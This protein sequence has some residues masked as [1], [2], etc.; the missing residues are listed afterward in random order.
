M[1]RRDK[2]EAL[3]AVLGHP[4]PLSGVEIP[5]NA[6][7][8]L[9]GK[10]HQSEVAIKSGLSQQMISEIERGTRHLTPE[11]A[12]KLAPALGVDSQQ[13]LLAH[14][15]GVL[16]KAAL[17]GAV[18]PNRLVEAVMALA[19][20][21]PDDDI[22]DQLVDALVEVLRKAVEN[23]NAEKPQAEP[24]AAMKTE[25]TRAR[26]DFAGRVT[27]KPHGKATTSKPKQPEGPRRDPSGRRI[28]KPHDPRRR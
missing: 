26:R 6:V 14:Q 10:R 15:I 19:E 8:D 25:K 22:S 17:K 20:T 7:R 5:E 11:V 27:D 23:Y 4:S 21:L 12:Q 1:W 9:R 3:A 18:D 13:L 16:N 2:L 28:N 24:Q